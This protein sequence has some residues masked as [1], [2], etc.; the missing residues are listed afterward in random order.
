MPEHRVQRLKST[1]AEN[2]FEAT[3][4]YL[5]NLSFSLRNEFGQDLS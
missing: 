2:C 4:I 5:Y 1:V 3:Y